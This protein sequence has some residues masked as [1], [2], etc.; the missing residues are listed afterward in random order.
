MLKRIFNTIF[1]C[2]GWVLG[3]SH[4]ILIHIFQI[5]MRSKLSIQKEVGNAV[6]TINRNGTVN[7]AVVDIS[8]SQKP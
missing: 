6:V 3:F 7:P 4:A 5:L 2:I 8:V 1:E